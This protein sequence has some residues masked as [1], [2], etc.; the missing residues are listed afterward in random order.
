VANRTFGRKGGI[1]LFT[2]FVLQLLAS[3]ILQEVYPKGS[4]ELETKETFWRWIFAAT[5]TALSLYLIVRQWREVRLA[6]GVA[7][8]RIKKAF[9][10]GAPA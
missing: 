4:H 10:F 3:T 6:F 8:G 7:I 2:L 1:S 5:Y 9:T